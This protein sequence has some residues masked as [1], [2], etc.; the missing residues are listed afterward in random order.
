MGYN[1]YNNKYSECSKINSV[2]YFVKTDS[3]YSQDILCA[4]KCLMK[5]KYPDQLRFFPKRTLSFYLYIL[6]FYNCFL[7]HIVE[8]NVVY[9][10]FFFYSNFDWFIFLTNLAQF[11]KA[12]FWSLQFLSATFMHHQNGKF[13]GFKRLQMS[14]VKIISPF[15]DILM[16]IKF[17]VLTLLVKFW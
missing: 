1:T 8:Y 9:L 5:S 13:I 3:F 6:T 15:K 17:N 16:S 12:C 11:V 4:L 7:L 14:Y 2:K 10:S